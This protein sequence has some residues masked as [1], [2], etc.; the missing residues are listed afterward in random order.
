MGVCVQKDSL[1]PRRAQILPGILWF[2]CFSASA[3]A[4]P[5]A[6]EV[7]RQVEYVNRFQALDNIRL[8][9]RRRPM[10]L[11]DRR[12]GGRIRRLTME[13]H[14][15]NRY[16]G[17]GIAARDLAI[18]RAGK[19]RGTAI[20]LTEFKDRRRN[21]VY[22]VW[23][24]SLRKIRRVSR[25]DP[26]DTW[27]GSVFTYGDVY[28]RRATDERHRLLPAQR[29]EGCLGRMDPGAEPR[30]SLP[31]WPEARCDLAGRELLRLESRPL[32]SGASYAYRITWVDPVTFAD[33][34]S[35]FFRDGRRVKRI[36]KDWRPTGL[37]DPRAQYWV[38]WYARAA[39]GHEGEAAVPPRA[40][41]WNEERDP[42]FWSERTLRR[43]KR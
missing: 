7:A 8:G 4:A 32:W 2:L 1:F 12:P 22:S 11:L 21:A 26:E 14:R 31:W 36:D 20:L 18:F 34:R 15:N 23:L 43:I 30:K 19:L 6:A 25:P 39:D 29:F 37:P 13:R 17:G 9:E 24:P 27:N 35:D 5:D 40:V 16:P 33:Y 42:G 38:Y 3:A 10:V 41:A 28:L